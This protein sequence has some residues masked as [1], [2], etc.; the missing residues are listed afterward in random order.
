M[1]AFSNLQVHLCPQK[2]IWFFQFQLVQWKIT[3]LPGNFVLHTAKYQCDV[4][5]PAFFPPD[6]FKVSY[7]F[8]GLCRCLN[9]SIPQWHLASLK[10]TFSLFFILFKI[11]WG[12]P[13]QLP[14]SAQSTNDLSHL[15]LLLSPQTLAY[16]VTSFDVSH[17][18]YK[19]SEA[20]CVF[21]LTRLYSIE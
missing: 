18:E 1:L 2:L 14:S 3:A 9:D 17:L 19:L 13:P 10:P 6:A 4:L 21:F 12:S 11:L 15:V 8:H 20:H 16:S 7:T 5:W